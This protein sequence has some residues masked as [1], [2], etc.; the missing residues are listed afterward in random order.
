M[1]QEL[2]NLGVKFAVIKMWDL[3]TWVMRWERELK[4][5][6]LKKMILFNFNRGRDMTKNYKMLIQT[7]VQ[8]KNLEIT[9]MRNKIALLRYEPFPV[10]FFQCTFLCMNICIQLVL[11]ICRF[12]IHGF[13]QVWIINIWEKNRKFQKAKLELAMCWALCW[14]HTK[15][16]MC[17]H[18][19]L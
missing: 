15:E 6:R 4:Q 12:H 1:R 11:F 19:L 17:R 3:Y 13:N 2:R 9:K 16:A 7:Y 10:Y 18:T 14:I 5:I 8:C